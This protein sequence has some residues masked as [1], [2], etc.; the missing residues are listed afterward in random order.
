MKRIKAAFL[1]M[2]VLQ[3]VHSIEEF[4]FRLY[5]VLPPI[6]FVYRRAPGLAMPAFILFNSFLVLFGLAC[7]LL[8]GTTCQSR[9]ESCDGCGSEFSLRQSRLTSFG[10]F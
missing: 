8:L 6:L 10:R 9:S 7:F 4:I 2:V 5:E 3:A 1:V